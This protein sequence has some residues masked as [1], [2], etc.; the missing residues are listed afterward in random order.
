MA[1]TSSSFNF[2]LDPQP[3]R[4]PEEVVVPGKTIRKFVPSDVSWDSIETRAPS[5]MPMVA[6]TQA[7]PMMIPNIVRA[8]R[9]LLRL[10]ARKLT[11]IVLMILFILLPDEAPVDRKGFYRHAS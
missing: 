11:R 4:A 1:S 10:I 7:T 2:E 9:I 8:A 5:P 6:I 3:P